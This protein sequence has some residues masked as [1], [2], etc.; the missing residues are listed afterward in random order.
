MKQE[1]TVYFFN[2]GSYEE[3]IS[4]IKPRDYS[5][6]VANIVMLRHNTV[7]ILFED[8]TEIIYSGLPFQ[9]ITKKSS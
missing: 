6:E 4:G 1:L 8:K 9:F 7:S 5:S 3:Y 2:N